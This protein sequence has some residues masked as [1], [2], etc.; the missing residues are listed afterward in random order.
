MGELSLEFMN[1]DWRD[2]RGSGRR[3]DRLRDPEW[4][5]QFLARWGLEVGAEPGRASLASLAALRELLWR[6]A[7]AI[8]ADREPEAGD[9]EALNG[10]LGASQA[11]RR[12]V[13]EGAGYR[14]ELVAPR[15]DWSW[16][17]AEIA[18]SFAGLLASRDPQRVKICNNPDCG[19]IFYDESKSRTRRW[20]DDAC[21]NLVKVRRFRGRR[22]G[23]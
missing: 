22:R 13:R 12:L 14:L 11:S 4:V 9:V 18:A 16:V 7:G 21:G 6:I 17:A 19:W 2:Y 5:R 23:R 8:A 20:C 15:R 1:S 10:V 3:E